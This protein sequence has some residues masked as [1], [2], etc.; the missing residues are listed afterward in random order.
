MSVLAVVSFWVHR[1]A[2]RVLGGDRRDEQRRPPPEGCWPILASALV[3]VVRASFLSFSFVILLVFV[4][5]NL[6]FFMGRFEGICVARIV[7]VSS[8][9]SHR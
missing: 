8:P 2:R 1:G 4:E 5:S 6:G 7:P 9:E 3:V